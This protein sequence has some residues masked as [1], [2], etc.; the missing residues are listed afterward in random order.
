MYEVQVRQA[1]D[2]VPDSLF[3]DLRLAIFEAKRVGSS[4][5]AVPVRVVKEKSEIEPQ[6]GVAEPLFLTGEESFYL[7]GKLERAAR[8]AASKHRRRTTLAGRHIVG[9]GGL[10]A[11]VSTVAIAVLV[12]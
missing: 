10:A 12:F 1:S 6:D 3:E 9:I 5:G 7:A 11:V 4:L 8:R 2:W